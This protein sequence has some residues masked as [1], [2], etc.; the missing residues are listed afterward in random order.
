MSANGAGVLVSQGTAEALQREAMEKQK[1]AQAEAQQRQLAAQ[2]EA[3][4]RAM[5]F[6]AHQIALHEAM[7]LGAKRP[8]SV[9]DNPQ[10]K[11]AD[12]II[13]DAKK[14]AKFLLGHYDAE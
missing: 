11:T 9:G 1:A 5:G 2:L 6:N 3:Q 13:A 10:V 14:F 4:E 12:E 7:E 8:A